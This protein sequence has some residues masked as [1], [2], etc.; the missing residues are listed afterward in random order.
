MK[1]KIIKICIVCFFIIF[2]PL[3]GCTKEG[4]KHN[5]AH[6]DKVL[7]TCIKD[8]NIEY[9]Q[10]NICKKYY[11]DN[12]ATKEVTYEQ[13]IL[14]KKNHHYND[15]SYNHD[16]HYYYCDLCG[17][18]FEEKAHEY[19]EFQRC[20]T[21]GYHQGDA[22]Y[23]DVIVLNISFSEKVENNQIIL[24]NQKLTMT[25]T[26]YNHLNCDLVNLVIMVDD[27]PCTYSVISDIYKIENI[28][29]IDEITTITFSLNLEKKSGTLEVKELNFINNNVVVKAMI[30]NEL[31]GQYIYH[32]VIDE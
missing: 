25:I 7:S 21:C 29:T 24:N 12:D 13:I 15:Y 20:I 22:T 19:D 4:H 1:R 18:T 17:K 32:N 16:Y 30:Q 6:F 3:I 14:P 9:Y 28:N 10:C 11:L 2:L 23:S 27:T 8:G 31:M 5:I 26:L